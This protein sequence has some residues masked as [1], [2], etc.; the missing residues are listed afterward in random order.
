MF[1]LTLLYFTNGDRS[2]RASISINAKFWWSHWW[3]LI[4]FRACKMVRLRQSGYTNLLSYVTGSK[5]Q[6]LLAIL[7]VRQIMRSQAEESAFNDT[8]RYFIGTILRRHLLSKE[9]YKMLSCVI[10][11]SHGCRC[12]NGEPALWIFLCFDELK[13]PTRC[14]W[15]RKASGLTIRRIRHDHQCK[16]CRFDSASAASIQLDK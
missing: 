16:Q 2:Q 8:L 12:M 9:G 6:S 10:D 1:L 15:S 3:K 14:F 13:V 5:A 7:T 4:Q 11:R